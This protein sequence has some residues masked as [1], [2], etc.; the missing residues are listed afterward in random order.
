LEET[1]QL[2]AALVV[3]R[4][5]SGQTFA[6]LC[7]V[8][9]A[10]RFSIA[11]VA[12]GPARSWLVDVIRRGSAV[13]LLDIVGSKQFSL[14]EVSCAAPGAEDL[15]KQLESSAEISGTENAA[16]VSAALTDCLTRLGAFEQGPGG[17]THLR[18]LL[19]HSS[20]QLH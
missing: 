15:T 18:F 7:L 17:G 19:P 20:K 12:V 16:V 8:S 11:A 1:S 6:L 10:W 2:N 14:L 9:G 13:V 3:A 4:V 5:Q